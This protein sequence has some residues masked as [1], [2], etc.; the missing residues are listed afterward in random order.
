MYFITYLKII[1]KICFLNFKIKRLFNFTNLKIF[2]NLMENKLDLLNIAS[3]KGI[4]KE[5]LNGGRYL[6]IQK[7]FT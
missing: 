2:I 6:L 5:F 3:E 1:D 4:V 7:L